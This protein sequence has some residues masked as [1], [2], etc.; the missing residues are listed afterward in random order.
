MGDVKPSVAP[1]PLAT[2]YFINKNIKI[3]VW[4]PLWVGTKG[5]NCEFKKL[6]DPLNHTQ[7]MSSKSVQAF[8]GIWITHIIEDTDRLMTILQFFITYKS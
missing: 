2:I 6:K 7:K 4:P 1:R 3:T 8:E 5:T